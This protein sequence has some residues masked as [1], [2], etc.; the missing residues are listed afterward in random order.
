MMVQMVLQL[1]TVLHLMMVLQLMTVL[2][3]M[4]SFS[5]CVSVWV[6]AWYLPKD[7]FFILSLILCVYK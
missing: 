3:L 2:Q 7:A 4:D 1:M 5:Q 6:K